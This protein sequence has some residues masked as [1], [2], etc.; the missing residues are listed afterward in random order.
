MPSDRAVLIFDGECGFCTASAHW[1]AARWH[2]DAEIVPWQR[3]GADGLSAR[4][5]AGRE[6]R[7]AAWWVDATGRYRGHR[8]VA[9]ALMQAGGW[10]RM[11]GRLIDT[12]GVSL[13]SAVGYRLVS[14]YRGHLP[15]VTPECSRPHPD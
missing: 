4:G 6:P 8:A 11:A 2:D 5:V 13:L 1:I 10:R 12:P 9:K 14:R 15:G 3:L 7:A